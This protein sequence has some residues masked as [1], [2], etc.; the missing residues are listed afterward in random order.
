MRLL[1]KYLLHMLHIHYKY[2]TK[3]LFNIL[4]TINKF[5]DF[6]EETQIN[7]LIRSSC[8]YIYTFFTINTSES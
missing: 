6:I 5:Y 1:S 7:L 3:L 2:K 8:K 4:P